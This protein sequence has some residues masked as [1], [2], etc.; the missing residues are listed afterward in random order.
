MRI[1]A[2]PPAGRLARHVAQGELGEG[3][4]RTYGT[5][6]IRRATAGTSRLDWRHDVSHRPTTRGSTGVFCARLLC[7][8]PAASAADAVHLHGAI[9]PDA[10]VNSPDDPARSLSPAAHPATHDAGKHSLACAPAWCSRRRR[11]Q[12]KRCGVMRGPATCAS[13]V[14]PWNAP[15]CRATASGSPR[16]I[17]R[18]SVR[19]PDCR[20]GS[21]CR[22][23][24]PTWRPSS[25][26]WSCRPWNEPAGI[27][28]GRPRCSGSIGTRSAIVDEDGSLVGIV[29]QRDLFQSALLRALG[30][31]SRARDHVLSS[32]VVK[33]VMT[34]P[35]IT[36]TPG[37]VLADAA[38]VMVERKIGCLPVV[39]QGALVGILTEGDFVGIVAGNR[40]DKTGVTAGTRFVGYGPAV[41]PVRDFLSWRSSAPSRGTRQWIIC[42]GKPRSAAPLDSSSGAS[43]VVSY[44]RRRRAGMSERRAIGRMPRAGH[45]RRRTDGVGRHLH[46]GYSAPSSEV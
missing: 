29:S 19:R 41:R 22:R 20:P 17:S 28:P 2:P 24:E 46:V 45:C 38:S 18:C 33:E 40:D 15:C 34:E 12:S 13:C 31:G 43:L 27:R 36:S 39:E 23:R 44:R 16:G 6:P 1:G 35:V 8:V 14:T 7:P 25:V 4:S 21:P 3:E 30:Y 32:V 26:T 10:V 9:R 11:R 5:R 42:R 37:T